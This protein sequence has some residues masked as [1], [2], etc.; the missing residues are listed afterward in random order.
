M[1]NRPSAEYINPD[2]YPKDIL[3]QITHTINED[4]DN[5]TDH[6]RDDYS[7]IR[8]YAI[9]DSITFEVDDAIS[10]YTSEGKNWI[11]IHIADPSSVIGIDSP[12]DNFAREKGTSIYLVDSIQPMLPKV[13]TEKVL[14]LNTTKKRRTISAAVNL[15]SRGN[16]QE[17]KISLSWYKPTYRLTYEDADQLIELAPPQ[18]IHLSLLSQLLELHRNMRINNGAQIIDGP[19]G[20]LKTIGNEPTLYIQNQSPSRRMVEEAM[21]L[22]GYVIADYAY[23]NS[24]S[25]PFRGQPNSHRIPKE[26][27]TR[28]KSKLISNFAITSSFY[29][30]SYSLSPKSHYSLGLDYYVHF[31]SPIRRYIDLVSHRQIIAFLLSSKG[32]ESS[33]LSQIIKQIDIKTTHAK[34]ITNND[35]YESLSHWL[36]SNK[37]L[38]WSAL[39][40]RWLHI[41]TKLALVC[42]PDIAINVTCHIRSDTQ[43]SLGDPLDILITNF[44]DSDHIVTFTET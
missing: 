43:L 32:I 13:L 5:Y 35:F 9:D 7:N 4:I 40:L 36:R 3:D 19:R 44:H 16:I 29:K 2:K 15:D 20:K 24:I 28:Y 30:S 41:N 18:D 14:S 17:Y 25:L 12:I 38:R 31:T 23:T 27:L 21:I 26:Y 34:H 33:L 8:G 10:F 37:Q 22:M 42:L 11:L 39:F 6:C 1:S